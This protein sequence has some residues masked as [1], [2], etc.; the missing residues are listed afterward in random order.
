MGFLRTMLGKSESRSSVEAAGLLVVLQ[1]FE[2]DLHAAQGSGVFDHLVE[3]P[4]AHTT[5]LSS[6]PQVVDLFPRST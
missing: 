2:G 5:G 4:P 1:D 3:K 6:P